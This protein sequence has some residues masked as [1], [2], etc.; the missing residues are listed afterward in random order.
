MDFILDK[1]IFIY[2]NNY[3]IYFKI[4]LFEKLKKNKLTTFKLKMKSLLI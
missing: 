2:V 4:I 1:F 3:N